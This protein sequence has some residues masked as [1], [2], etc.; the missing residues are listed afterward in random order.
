MAKSILVL[1]NS[2]SG[3][4]DFRK[5]VLT[6]LMEEGYSVHVSV[7]DTGYLEKIKALG[8][9]CHET[10]MERRGMNPAKDLKLF[11]FYMRLL[12]QVKPSA[13][14]T[15]TI[16]PN[17]YGCMACRIQK[18][19][20]LVNI[21]GLGTALEGGGMLQKMLVFMYRT[22]IKKAGCVFFQNRANKAFMLEKGCIL[23]GAKTRII[24]GS[25]VNLQQYE[26]KPYPPK[27]PVRFVTL[28]RIMKAK[29]IDELLTAAEIIHQEYPD[30]VFELLGAYEKEERD[31]YEPRIQDL[32][33]RGIVQYYGYRDD[34]PDFYAHSQAVVHPTYS[35][36][37]SNVLLEAAATG[38]PAIAS[39]IDGI[40][41]ICEDGV[42]GFL[43][44]AK[45]ADSMV[46]A[47]R[48]F[49]STP[50]ESRASMGR[51]ARA[52]VEEN[53]DRR[54]VVAAYLEEIRELTDGN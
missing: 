50:Y 17:I 42:T 53:F 45:D 15:Y 36:G 35:E 24:P 8:C 10:V 46:N 49:L 48:A 23:P 39:N 9:V 31:I 44:K 47:I 16:K 54:Q 26:P 11:S 20:Y 21:T 43:F 37:M 32:Q 7:P 13:V 3:L 29:G 14:L 6:A 41:E 12:K 38:R 1:G 5:E 22:S 19:P 30:T 52:F 27:E 4:Y 2:D 40:K 34:V 25:G 18:V 51:K 33:S 28:I